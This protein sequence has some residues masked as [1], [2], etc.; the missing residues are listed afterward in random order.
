[1]ILKPF[2]ARQWEKKDPDPK[3]KGMG[4]SGK[5]A[6][7]QCAQL[8]HP[9]HLSRAVGIG[10]RRL[11]PAQMLTAVERNHLSCYRTRFQKETQA[12]THLIKIRPSPQ[13]HRLQL[14]RK[15]LLRL[16]GGRKRETRPDPIDPD[17]RCQGEGQLA[18]E[19]PKP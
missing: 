13:R 19:A 3:T 15:L 8:A 18:G 17:T 4:D 11:S 1:M 5:I 6:A 14:A 12:G 9:N 16:I 7:T 10:K 2:H